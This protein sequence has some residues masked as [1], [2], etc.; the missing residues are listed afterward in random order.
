MYIDKLDDIVHKYN[1]TYHS[2]IK[3]KPA[4]VKSS[5]Y[6]DFDKNNNKVDPKFEVS[7]QVRILEYKNFFPKGYIPIYSEE[8]F[9]ITKVK[10]AVSWTCENWWS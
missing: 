8:V 3:M 7:D 2:T 9:V 10:N 1:Y 5:T 4:D 6:I